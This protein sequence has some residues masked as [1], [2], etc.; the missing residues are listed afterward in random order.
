MAGVP[1]VFWSAMRATS[2]MTGCRWGRDRCLWR[3]AR[4]PAASGGRISSRDRAESYINTHTSNGVL[5]YD[6]AQ[7]LA[8]ML[9]SK[10]F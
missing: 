2:G 4:S 6:A 3:A 10:S 1:D 8:A 7:D 9:K 5:S